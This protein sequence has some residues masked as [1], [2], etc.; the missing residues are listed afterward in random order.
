MKNSVFTYDRR[1]IDGYNV[2]DY[3]SYYYGGLL[4][5][6]KQFPDYFSLYSIEV[7]QKIEEISY[8]LYGSVDYA[9]IILA[10]NNNV[11]L[12]SSPYNSD[13]TYDQTIALTGIISK[14]LD[15]NELQDGSEARAN[16][17][18]VIDN[19]GNKVNTENT[20][21]KSITVPK[22]KKLNTLLAIINNYRKDNR[23][24]LDEP[25]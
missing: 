4:E 11:F 9:D 17:E 7:D 16:L 24:L 3:T 12:W 6:F 15:Y 21:R 19:I 13:I 8:E 23:M 5:L 25:E 20:N 18:R 10:A 22:P 14:E 2:T 1:E